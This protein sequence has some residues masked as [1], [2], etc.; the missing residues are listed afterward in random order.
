MKDK[1]E[2]TRDSA[3]A[4]SAAM[5]AVEEDINHNGFT[6]SP[7]LTQ[8][9]PPILI[10]VTITTALTQVHLVLESAVAVGVTDVLVGVDF[11]VVCW[12]WWV[13][14]GTVVTD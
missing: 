2:T 6:N 5:G 8:L 9:L 3:V 4:A 13:A 14:T 1:D 11:G 10:L 7:P 12:L